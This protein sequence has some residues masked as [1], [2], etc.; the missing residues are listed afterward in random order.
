[1]TDKGKVN[2]FAWCLAVGRR[3]PRK[4]VKDWHEMPEAVQI[5]WRAAAEAVLDENYYE[6][7]GQGATNVAH[8]SV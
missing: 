1:M 7:G 2:Y 5:A 3:D 6:T 4:V 8:H